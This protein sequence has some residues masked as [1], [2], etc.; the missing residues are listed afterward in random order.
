M[1]NTQTLEEVK[2]LFLKAKSVG[3]PLFIYET[4]SFKDSLKNIL[5]FLQHE[6][7]LLNKQL[8]K[9]KKTVFAKTE[10]LPVHIV[11]SITRGFYSLDETDK[12]SES[13]AK[14][15]NQKAGFPTPP[16]FFA[17]LNKLNDLPEGS[18]VTFLEADNFFLQYASPN[19]LF[20]SNLSSSL[21]NVEEWFKLTG[22]SLILMGYCF[23]VPEEFTHAVIQL[24]EPNPTQ[25]ELEEIV[26]HVYQAAGLSVPTPA[27]LRTFAFPLRG[28]SKSVAENFASL[29]LE[30][31]SKG[32][33]IKK[34]WKLKEKEINATQGLRFM[35]SDVTLKD[36]GGLGAVKKQLVKIFKGKNPPLL[37]LFIDE[38]EKVF[39]H[40]KNSER[41]S[42]SVNADILAQWLETF[43]LQRWSMLLLD[44]VPGNAKSTIARAIA[45]EFGDRG[46]IAIRADIN[47][48][49][50]KFVGDS[51]RNIRLLLKRLT[52]IGGN[53]VLVIAAGNNTF[54]LSEAFMSRVNYAT[55]YVD[56]PFLEQRA[57]IWAIK[58]KEHK[59]IDPAEYDRIDGITDPSERIEA[60]RAHVGDLL[61]KEYSGRDIDNVARNAYEL[62]DSL[63]DAATVIIPQVVSRPEDINNSRN[64]AHKK[65][66]DANLGGY[67][68]NK[69][70][71][72]A[73][74][75]NESTYELVQTEGNPNLENNFN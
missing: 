15:K 4:S 55:W 12:S 74:E 9:S 65:M 35:H 75:L 50:G 42:S 20:R 3:H 2:E 48:T 63:Q 30:G 64:K 49:K 5:D 43:S 14:L 32:V 57:D 16:D 40:S 37:V 39:V 7:E 1:S 38:V 52:A 6:K 28:C 61:D 47:A 53:D 18:T 51:E 19:A 27:A 8:S 69:A 71:L 46:V 22:S 44:G 70:L 36:V 72:N 60:I 34:L 59:L 23:I 58:L 73:E 11:W 41:E 29:A 67:F 54:N 45:N 26:G 68:L 21:R 31:K 13:L 24:N 56:L 66:L 33:S 25:E 17:D 10:A 62:N